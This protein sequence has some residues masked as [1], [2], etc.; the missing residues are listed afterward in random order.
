MS[1]TREQETL[2]DADARGERAG[3]TSGS[4]DLAAETFGRLHPGVTEVPLARRHRRMH[5]TR[6]GIVAVALAVLGVVVS[7]FGPWGAG[8]GLVG[9]VI[10]IAALAR[11]AQPAAWCWAAIAGGFAS[12]LFSAYWVAW[13]LTQVALVPVAG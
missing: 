8:F 5:V 13:I 2:P 9:A 11:K 1:S 12:I 3:P 4:I 7:W 10:G 6:V